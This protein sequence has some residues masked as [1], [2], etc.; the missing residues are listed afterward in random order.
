MDV[1]HLLTHYHEKLRVTNNNDDPYIPF[2][3]ELLVE[4]T[5]HR[6]V[7]ITC[8]HTIKLLY[9]IRRNTNNNLISSFSQ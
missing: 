3:F 2:S 8:V 7:M 5:L 6:D 1:F 9:Y 4:H